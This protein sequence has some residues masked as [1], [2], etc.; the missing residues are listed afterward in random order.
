MYIFDIYPGTK[1]VDLPNHFDMYFF[2]FKIKIKDSSL[3]YMN[4]VSQL[5]KGYL[6]LNTHSDSHCL[7]FGA[8]F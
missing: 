1:K 8:I 2:M 5:K 7:N 6:P 4:M 3:N